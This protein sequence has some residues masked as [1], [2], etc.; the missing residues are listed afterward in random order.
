MQSE[1]KKLFLHLFM[2]KAAQAI[3]G[4]NFL[5]GLIEAMKT[6]R[7]NPLM[8][9]EC[10][11]ASNNT[12]IRWNKKVFKDKI[13]VIEYILLTHREA[14]EQGFNIL[15]EKNKK[16]RKNILNMIRTLSPI[17]FVVTPQNPY[18]GEGFSFQVFNVIEEENI[19]FNPI[20]IAMF[21][22]SAEF[23]KKAIKY[24]N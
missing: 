20:F 5:L 19:E 3:G 9:K 1:D 15:N 24:D 6:K 14:Q 12:I 17:E 22:C 8:V 11:I 7:P 4:I 10:Q 23:T 21:F 2:Q 16:K 13:D 18:D